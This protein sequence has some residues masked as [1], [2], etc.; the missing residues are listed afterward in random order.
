[1]RAIAPGDR[2]IQVKLIAVTKYAELDW[3]RE[4]LD[5]GQ[6]D[7][8]ESRPQQLVKR[9]LVLPGNVC[10]HM[11]GHLQRNKADDILAVA[12]LIHSVDSVR[13]FDHLAKSAHNCNHRQRILIEINVA[14]EASKD[15]FNLKE[16][17]DVWP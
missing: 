2:Q 16:L 4:L 5:L 8:G 17:L 7:L 15:G 13:L 10:W 6:T 1:M 11:I 3:V 12:N 9:A 14:N